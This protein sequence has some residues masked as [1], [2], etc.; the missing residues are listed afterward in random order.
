MWGFGR[1]ERTVADQRE[2]R[3]WPSSERHTRNDSLLETTDVV[4]CLLL[5]F[6]KRE[7]L[8]RREKY[9]AGR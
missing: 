7:I 9:E 2:E 8:T 4:F 6:F 3:V 1:T 5:L